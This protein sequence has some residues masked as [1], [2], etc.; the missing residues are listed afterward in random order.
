MVTFCQ[1]SNE[2][3]TEI[4]VDEGKVLQAAINAYG[5]SYNAYFSDSKL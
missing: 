1:C 3:S 4:K 5:G 2:V